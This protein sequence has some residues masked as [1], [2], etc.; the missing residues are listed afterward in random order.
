MWP[1]GF[2]PG[3]EKNH[4]QIAH[5]SFYPAL[6][7]VVQASC[8]EGERDCGRK[9]ERAHLSMA[10]SLPVHSPLPPA[11]IPQLPFPPLPLPPRHSWRQIWEAVVTATWHFLEV[12]VCVAWEKGGEE[13]DGWKARPPGLKIVLFPTGVLYLSLLLHYA[14]KTMPAPERVCLLTIELVLLPSINTR[15]ESM[16]RDFHKKRVIRMYM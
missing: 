8:G 5:C 16:P 3:N 2:Y 6:P 1:S 12:S 14:V 13:V 10:R 9:E 11:D 15:M 4:A 7:H